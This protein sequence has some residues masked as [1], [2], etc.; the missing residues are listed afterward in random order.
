MIY[1][2][3]KDFFKSESDFATVIHREPQPVFP[4]HSHEF[5]EIFVVDS[6][7]GMHEVNGNA[8]ALYPGVVFF[9]SPNDSHLFDDVQN[10]HLIN[11]IYS[12]EQ[13]CH[14]IKNIHEVLP[15]VDDPCW[16]ITSKIRLELV[17]NLNHF[18]NIDNMTLDK[19]HSQF[20]KE[21][22]FFDV[23]RLFRKSCYQTREIMSSS[24]KVKH[25]LI[26]L[27]TSYHNDIDW[28]QLAEDFNLSYRTLHRTFNELMGVSPN[29]YLNYL[30]LMNSKRLLENQSLSIT[31][32]AYKVGFNDSNYF[33]NTFSKAFDM[34]PSNYRKS[35]RTIVS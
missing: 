1:L 10:L 29:R 11:L 22:V 17:K 24:D 27:D 13:H 28:E 32:I 19:N 5:H 26:Y 23:I 12:H 6:G 33:T 16:N 30:K 34:T 25:L 7:Y 15:S 9:I 14:F 31:D 21:S 2:S 35:K 18:S 3:N 4:E 8:Y 20:E